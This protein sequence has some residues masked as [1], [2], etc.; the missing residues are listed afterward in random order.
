MTSSTAC[1]AVDSVAASGTLADNYCSTLNNGTATAQGIICAS[2]T[3]ILK[4]FQNFSSD[5]P[6]LSGLLTP[7][8]V[9]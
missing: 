9:T 6:S 8:A 3:A 4:C 5:Q 2:S 1:I 7:V